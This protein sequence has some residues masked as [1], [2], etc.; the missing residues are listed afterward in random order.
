MHSSQHPESY[1]PKNQTSFSEHKS[2]P[3]PPSIGVDSGTASL[4][5]TL[6]RIFSDYNDIP[7]GV[8]FWDGSIWRSS[9]DYPHFEVIL[10]DKAAW[11]T[12]IAKPDEASLGGL[13]AK[14]LIEVNGDLYSALRAFPKM[15]AAIVSRIPKALLHGRELLSRLSGTLS[16]FDRLGALHSQQ[17]DAA[18]IS[19][20][21]DKP[22]SFYRRWL[23]PSMV[24][25]CAYFR[26]WKNDLTT[27]Q[28]DKMD[29]I[30]QKLGLKPFDRYLDIG[31]GW[32]SLLMHAV[33]QYGVWGHGVSLSKEQVDFAKQRIAE[34]DRGILCQVSL[35]DYRK[36]REIYARFDKVSSV[37]MCEHV[38]RKNIKQY[39]ADVYQMLAG[40]GLF[41]NHGITSSLHVPKKRT[42]FIDRYVF[43]DGELL[44]ISEMTEAA[45]E[46]GFEVRDLENLREHYEETL[47]RW[48]AD[49]RDNKDEVIAL[50]D[51]TT[52]RVWE[53]YMV[54][55]AEAF[56]RGEI[57]VYQM[58]LSKNASGR[59]SATKTREEWY[60]P[61][62]S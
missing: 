38:G 25:S 9:V 34:Q 58:L 42:S 10:N 46:A 37:G 33:Q 50:T 47:H 6:D 40:G 35:K 56:R 23:G 19:H 55:S 1:V 45:E 12:L 15:E 54:G 17:R 49:L 57:A 61:A 13:Y 8:R 30:C 7:F 52:Y 27:A 28:T 3:V 60:R 20:H 2:S 4:G 32:G 31:C 24:Y 39:F 36:L 14:G 48:V 51:H 26:D 41:L 18:A 59:S 21:Y 16:R 22:S 29:L 11:H 5:R 62:V 44:S 43:P 53:L